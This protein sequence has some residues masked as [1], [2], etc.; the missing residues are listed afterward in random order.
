FALIQ[1]GLSS[2]GVWELRASTRSIRRPSGAIVIRVLL[3]GDGLVQNLVEPCRRILRRNRSSEF[4]TDGSGVSV[5]A[6]ARDDVLISVEFIATV[7]RQSVHRHTFVDA[8]P[9]GSD[10]AVAPVSV[11]EQPDPGAAFDRRGVDAVLRE[12]SDHGVLELRDEEA[13]ILGIVEA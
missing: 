10:L 5:G 12:Q 3:G 7:Q 1:A 2:I 4:S 13:D 11:A 6:P 8:D 9:D